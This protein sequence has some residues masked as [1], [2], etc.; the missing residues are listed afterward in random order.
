MD[1]AF[2]VD[3]P[4]IFAIYNKAAQNNDLP[5]MVSG[6]RG[7]RGDA[8]LAEYQALTA[9]H[10]AHQ[11]TACRKC[12]KLCPQNIKIADRMFEIKQLVSAAQVG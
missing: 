6:S 5:M 1:C 12:E 7:N 11:C 10:Q 8:F 9:K 3:I 2:G 4:A